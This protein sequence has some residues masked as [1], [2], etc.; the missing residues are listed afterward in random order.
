[1]F[2]HQLRRYRLCQDIFPSFFF[3]S[4]KDLELFYSCVLQVGFQ[5]ISHRNYF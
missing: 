2:S 4:V 1:M 3:F 5:G